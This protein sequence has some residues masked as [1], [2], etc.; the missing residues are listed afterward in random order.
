MVPFSFPLIYT[1][2]ATT[3]PVFSYQARDEETQMSEQYAGYQFMADDGVILE[4]KL[5]I[6]CVVQRF[7]EMLTLERETLIRE[8]ERKLIVQDIRKSRSIS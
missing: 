6:L 1:R 2:P 3:P 5:D 8:N 4:Q 7:V